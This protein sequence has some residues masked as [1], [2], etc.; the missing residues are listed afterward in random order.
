MTNNTRKAVETIVRI[1][2]RIEANMEK[3]YEAAEFDALFDGGEF[4]GPELDRSLDREANSI[5]RSFGFRDVA[6]VRKAAQIIGMRIN[7][8]QHNALCMGGR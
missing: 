5:A 3:T 2:N 6:T 8:S 1:I 7:E 4:S